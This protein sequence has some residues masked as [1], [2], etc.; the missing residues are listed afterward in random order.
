VVAEPEKPKTE[1]PEPPQLPVTTSQFAQVAVD[2][3]QYS[4]AR[5]CAH[6]FPTAERSKRS[7]VERAA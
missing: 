2:A 6:V 7:S 3:T 5:H 1:Q 4:V